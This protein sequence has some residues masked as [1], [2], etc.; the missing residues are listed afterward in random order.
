M[1]SMELLRLAGVSPSQHHWK[2]CPHGAANDTNSADNV[3]AYGE[4]LCQHLDV[5]Y[6]KRKVFRFT[7][8]LFSFQTI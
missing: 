5:T 7:E 6:T 3:E 4:A 2:R 8:K 1:N